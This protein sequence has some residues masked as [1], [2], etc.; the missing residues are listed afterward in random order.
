LVLAAAYSAVNP[1]GEAPDEADHWAYIVHL[2]T[3]RRL[4]IGPALTQSKHPPLYHATAALLAESAGPRGGFLLPNADVRDDA[5][6]EAVAGRASANFFVHSAR[7]AWPWRDGPLAFHIARLW[8]VLLSTFVVWAAYSLMR[9]VQPER[10]V[11]ALGTAGFLA[12]LPELAFIGG[13]ANND[14]M[15]ALTAALALWGSLRI[16]RHRGDWR[17]G[18]WT[19]LALGLGL[20]AKVST[21]GVWPAVGL[22]ILLSASQAAKPAP[23]DRAATGRSWLR[24]LTTTCLML[25]GGL[26]IASPWFV[27]NWRLYGDPLGMKLARQ[28]IDL[29]PGP[30]TGADTSWLLRGWFFSFWGKFGGAGHIPMSSWIYV[31]LAVLCAAAAI[32]LLRILA[33]SRSR[34]VWIPLGILA[35]AVLGTV[36]VIWLYSVTALGTDQGRLLYPALA[37]LAGLL[38]VGLIACAPAARERRMAIGLTGFSLFL[39]LYGLFGVIVPAY[40]P[41]PAAS[42]AAADLGMPAGPFPIR[43][44]EIELLGWT[45]E[46]TGPVLFWHAPERP[47]QDWQSVV[48]VVAVD[49]AMVWEWRH[50]P[51]G[52]RLSTDRWPAGFVMRDPYAVRWPDWA[53]PGSYL[54]EVGLTGPEGDIVPPDGVQGSPFVPLGRL[55]QERS[56]P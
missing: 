4:P 35:L 30:W 7:E 24:G 25:G 31:V 54:L 32:G 36:V 15:A 14:V 49:G 51:G 6:R 40:S 2:A 34:S 16:Y 28:T 46:N 56:G 38:T 29:R 20:W 45:A 10:P 37:P 11:V 33:S 42:E 52:G 43:F 17:A 5:G 23:V 55:E 1:L 44:G 41:P 12:F 50:V 48:R 47:S 27:R 8:N 18:W 39:G 9:T 3:E 22:A 13:A 26:L 21:F 53:T 19:P